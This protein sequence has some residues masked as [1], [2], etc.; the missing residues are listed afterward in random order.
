MTEDL[1][2]EVTKQTE[3]AAKPA[4]EVDENALTARQIALRDGVDDGA[5]DRQINR[6]VKLEQ[7]QSARQSKLYELIRLRDYLGEAPVSPE[8]VA[9]VVSRV[10]ALIDSGESFIRAAKVDIDT[11]RKGR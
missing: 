5:S 7:A 2:Q 10:N 3:S 1:Y 11:L 9:V 8:V 6:L 4:P